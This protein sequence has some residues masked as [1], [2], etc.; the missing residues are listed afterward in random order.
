PGRRGELRR[1]RGELRAQ[2]LDAAG[3]VALFRVLQ[4]RAQ[5]ADAAAI[6]VARARVEHL[7]GVAGDRHRPAVRSRR[8][9][10]NRRAA[11]RGHRVEIAHV[12]SLPR[13]VDEPGEE[14]EAARMTQ[15]DGRPVVLDAPEVAV[16]LEDR[17]LARRRRRPATRAVACLLRLRAPRLRALDEPA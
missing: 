14:R 6:L 10:R 8:L 4:L 5:L 15:E 7:S 17:Y 11:G 1:Q 2:G 3:V 13:G 12:D 16:L 9:A